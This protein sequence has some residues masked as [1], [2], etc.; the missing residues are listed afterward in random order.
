MCH[1]A[2]CIEGMLIEHYDPPWNSESIGLSFGNK[3]KSL[4]H[5]YHVD[6]DPTLREN[7]CQSFS[8]DIAL[9]E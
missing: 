3:G 8:N 7:T 4:W 6:Q 5:Q 1:Y 2:P 9:W